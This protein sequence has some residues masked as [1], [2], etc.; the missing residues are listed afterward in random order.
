MTRAVLPLGQ[1]ELQELRQQRATRKAQKQKSDSRH[2]TAAR[3]AQRAYVDTII[4]D[5]D[6]LIG[7]RWGGRICPGYRNQVLF[8]RG[9]F[10]AR[11]I[12]LGKLEDALLAFGLVTCDLEIREMRQIAGSIAARISADGRGYRYS[13]VGA[14]EALKI[15]AEEVRAG[16]LLCV[17]P[18]DPEFAEFRRQAKRQRDRERKADQRRAADIQIRK[19]ARGAPWKLMDYRSVIFSGQR[20][21][22]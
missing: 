17:H 2:S 5:I 15:T 11:R 19:P 4:A 7:Y 13:T 20:L 16:R 18:R 8:L 12:G 10:V 1:H 21:T 14:A 3:D 22:Y 6:R 9:S